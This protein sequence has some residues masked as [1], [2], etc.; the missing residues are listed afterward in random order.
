[1]AFPAKTAAFLSGE[2]APKQTLLGR[3]SPRAMCQAAPLLR[4]MQADDQ[5]ARRERGVKDWRVEL[6]RRRAPRQALGTSKVVL[7]GTAGGSNPKATRSGYSN[8]V[9]VNGH[10]YMVDCGEGANT[11]LWRAGLDVN[12]SPARA[13]RANVAAVFL[14]HLHSDHV[15]DFPNL[16]LG[17]WPNRPIDVYGPAPAGLPLP[18]YP[19]GRPMPPL[20]NPEDP[21]PGTRAMAD[22]LMNAFSYNINLRIT[23][24]SRSNIAELINVHELGI[25][26]DGYRPDIDLGVVASGAS[27]ATAAPDMEP[28]V[29]YPEDDNGVRV[30]AVL[31]QHAPAFPAFAYR[32]DTPTGSVVF[33]GDTGPCENVVR[34]ARGADILVHEVIDLEWMKELLH[35]LP[36][37]EAVINHLGRAHSAPDQVGDIA[38]RA[39]VRTLVLSHLVP[40]DGEVSEDEWEAK[41]RPHFS[42]EIVC[43]VDLDE[44]EL[45]D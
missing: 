11:Q 36:N 39:G 1:V 4:Q 23:D 13:D 44:F 6:A 12:R 9:V 28:I 33:S 2:R 35:R 14:T 10:G 20:V 26:R 30:T 29:V 18:I 24:E 19:P 38:S 3:Y 16:F 5:D 21:T 42:G 27:P 37:G 8:A 41:V 45:C 31:V 17:G 40:G 32:F 15:I 22:H 25:A 7:L 34:L 43:G